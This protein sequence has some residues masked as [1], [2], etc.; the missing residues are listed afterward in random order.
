[1]VTGFRSHVRQYFEMTR[2][3]WLSLLITAAVAGFCLTRSFFYQPGATYSVTLVA[4][5]LV[6]NVIAVFLLLG[7]HV[8]AQKLAGIFYGVKV[9]YD[10]YTLG[11]LIGAFITFLSFG[12]WPLFITGYLTYSSIPN[13]R[14]GK[15]RATFP[16][17]WEMSLIAVTGPLT[18][19]LLTIPLNLLGLVTGAA[20]FHHLIII[21]ILIAIY[22]MLPL[23]LLQTPN[24]YQVYMSR[25]ESLESN[26]PGFD[27][28]F[29]APA[30]Y[31]FF[32]G[33]IATFALLALLFS[34]TLL[35]LLL[36]IILGF[37][38]MYLYTVVRETVMP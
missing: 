26:L 13:L 8:L 19:I 30:W 10:K 31:F 32:A 38:T 18:S 28:F 23:P 15:F 3:E 20:L 6:T 25:M 14:I 1:M 33:I 21:T 29:A 2:R 9:V 16:K 12:Y 34:P 37:G 36:S 24:P 5:D 11:L 22:A 35:V 4:G 27:I 17:K 7:L